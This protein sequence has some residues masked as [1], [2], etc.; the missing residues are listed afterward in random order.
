M[1]K[2]LQQTFC[3]MP[4]IGIYFNDIFWDELFIYDKFWTFIDNYGYLIG[5]YLAWSCS[6]IDSNFAKLVR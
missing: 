4:A 2:C 5:L 6:K 1:Q 3:N